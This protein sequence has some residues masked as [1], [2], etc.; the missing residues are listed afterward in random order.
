MFGPSE[1]YSEYFRNGCFAV[2]LDGELP[3]AGI[4]KLLLAGVLEHDRH[5]ALIAADDLGGH[6]PVAIEIMQAY[7]ELTREQEVRLDDGEQEPA[8]LVLQSG[9][10]F[11]RMQVKAIESAAGDAAG[12]VVVAL[13]TDDLAV[14][15]RV[16][17]YVAKSRLQL[18]I[19][20]LGEHDAGAVARL[21]R[22]IEITAPLKGRGLHFDPQP[23]WPAPGRGRR[24]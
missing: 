24:T 18:L 9:H 20:V 21:H 7:L 11:G 12:R 5:V 6:L 10:S 4:A 14:A 15:E 17:N 2:E 3:P 13:V 1:R 16:G 19:G 23:H 22:R 8:G